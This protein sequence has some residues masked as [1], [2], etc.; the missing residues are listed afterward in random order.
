MKNFFPIRTVSCCV[1][2]CCCSFNLKIKPYNKSFIDQACSVNNAYVQICD[3]DEEKK[4]KIARHGMPS[5]H[6]RK[7][8]YPTENL[9][10]LI[11]GVWQHMRCDRRSPLAEREEEFEIIPR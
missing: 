9:T 1:L 6:P 4:K 10:R 5:G 11:N 8:K 3:Y 2:F 7:K